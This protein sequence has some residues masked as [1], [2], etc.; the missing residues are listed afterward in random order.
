LG[1]GFQSRRENFQ[2][3]NAE[4]LLLSDPQSFMTVVQEHDPERRV[5]SLHTLDD[6]M[7]CEALRHGIFNDRAALPSLMR[8]Y[9]EVFLQAPVDRRREIYGHLTIIVPQ[10]GGRTAGALTPFMLLDP[11]MG[12]VSTATID[13]ASLGSLLNDDPMTRPRDAISMIEKGIPENPAAV[14]GGLLA[15]ADPRVCRLLQ[16]LRGSLDEHQVET[17]TKCFSGV[18]AKCVVEFYLDWLEELVDRRDHR[19]LSI[20]GHVAAG[21]YRLADRRKI[22]FI[23]DGPRPFPVPQD[24]DVPWPDYKQLDPQ[25]FAVSIASRLFDLERREPPPKVL[26]HAIRAFGLTPRTASQDIALMQ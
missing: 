1:F 22:P 11:D 20:F 2:M 19:S 6:L 3:S 26:P 16:P 25:E 13:Y 24:E 17:V 10:L 5:R 4:P 15:L 18:T 23:A 21:L 7:I 14:I 8:F 12:I 9:N